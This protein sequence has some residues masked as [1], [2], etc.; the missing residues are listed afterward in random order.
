MVAVKKNEGETL[1]KDGEHQW[2]LKSML[3]AAKITRRETKPRAAS[4][5]KI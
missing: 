4:S 2:R 1:R 3:K 5:H